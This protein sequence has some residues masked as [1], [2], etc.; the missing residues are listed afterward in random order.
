MALTLLS[1]GLVVYSYA[2]FPLLLSRLS[3]GR[4]LPGPV[5][6]PAD[7]LPAVDV[8][9]AVHN[10]EVVLE[11]KI[12]ATFATTYPRTHL[13]LLVGSDGSTD[14][15]NALLARLATEFP[16]LHYTAFAERQGK[17]GVM[18]YL[19]AQATAPVLVLT[20]ANVFF[21]PTTLFELVKYFANPH[22]GLVGANVLAPPML[23]G[24]NQGITA[25]E[26]AYLARENHFKYQESVIWGAAM[27]AHG[28]AFAVRRAAY[29]PAPAGFV[30]DDFFTSMAALR[31]GYQ[32]LLN[33][34]A[35]AT[36]DV[37]YHVA[38]EF[39]RKARISVGNFQNAHEFRRLLWPP[40]RG[41]AFAFW[42]HKVLRWLTPHLLLLG[43]A[44]S[45]ALVARGAGWFWQLAL[46]GQVALP[47]LG[48][49]DWLLR[50]AGGPP[51]AGLRYIRHFYVM[52]A[53]LLLGWWRYLRRQRSAVWRPT[54]R[55]QHAGHGPPPR[56]GP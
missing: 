24:P 2:G 51:V 46:V 27:G 14:H 6:S 37:G 33:P 8:L 11:Q 25:Q 21:E 40:W 38:E 49:L 1:G 9:L 7:A 55:N 45:M 54:A 3:R 16:Q 56:V 53:A 20:D 41:V 50:R 43:L 13:R 4:T 44:A 26:S 18:Q 39:R 30:V 52:N 22:V 31:A 15:T 19:S 10:E 17:P 32:V 35:R 42:S 28:G 34:A 47:L 29:T 48:G 36:E 12:R 5:H 23:A